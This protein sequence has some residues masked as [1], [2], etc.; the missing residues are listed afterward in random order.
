MIY[1]SYIP[2]RSNYCKFPRAN[3]LSLDFKSILEKVSQQLGIF[4]GRKEMHICYGERKVKHK[5]LRPKRASPLI[6]IAPQI[7]TYDKQMK[8]S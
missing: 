1:F 2:T 8:N 5:P 3:E 4:W 6:I 7:K